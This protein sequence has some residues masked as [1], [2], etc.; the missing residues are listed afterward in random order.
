MREL[1]VIYSHRDEP[2]VERLAGDIERRVSN[3]KVFYDRSME[4]DASWT[5]T[6]AV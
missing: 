6:L 5:A 3:V 2:F 1:V 4:A